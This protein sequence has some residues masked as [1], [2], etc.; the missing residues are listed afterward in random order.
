MTSGRERPDGDTAL[1]GR[2]RGR[3]SGEVLLVPRP[4]ITRQQPPGALEECVLHRKCALNP[5]W[6]KEGV[7]RAQPQL[8]FVRFAAVY[9]R[10]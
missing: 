4:G 7:T 5:D 3:V 2:V 1:D 10:L 8:T 6:L 9:R